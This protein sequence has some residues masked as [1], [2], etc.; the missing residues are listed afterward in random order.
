MAKPKNLSAATK[1]HQKRLKE[2]EKKRRADHKN[3]ARL[4]Q[5]GPVNPYKDR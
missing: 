2:E 5:F 4:R 1:A 3:A